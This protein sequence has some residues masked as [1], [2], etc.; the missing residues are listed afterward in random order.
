MRVLQLAWKNLWHRPLSALLSI[1][2]TALAILLVTVVLQVS[3]QTEQRFLRNVAGIDMVI[4]AKGSPLQL[5]LSS[6]YHIDN[7]TGNIN[8]ARAQRYMRNP[9]VDK[10]I[11]LSYGDSYRGY[12]IV[13][14]TTD[15]VT[16]YGVELEKGNLFQ[17]DMEVVLGAKVAERLNLTIGGHFHGT[18]GMEE[19]DDEHVH[20]GHS[21][22]VVGVLKESQTVLDQ[23]ILCNM[24]SV[25]AVHKEEAD[26][27]KPSEK[28]ITAVLLSFR[29]PMGQM[30]LPRQVNAENGMQAALPAI[31]VNRMLN[32]MGVGIQTL[33]SLAYLIML[34]AGLSVFFS[35]LN[36]LKE[37]KYELAL[38]R[39]LGARPWHLMGLL[40]V[41]GLLVVIVGFLTGL[42]MSRLT[43]WVLSL[44]FEEQFQFVLNP[45][46]VAPAEWGLL[47]GTL[48]LGLL[49]SF[50][51][52]LRAMNINI[53]KTLSGD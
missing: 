4:G 16:H 18:H 14:T 30:I 13:G 21:Y 11:P 26:S 19:K 51:P 35:M 42:V 8:Y 28:D 25:W 45:W 10:A 12:R 47:G 34:L 31:E 38:L 20:E 9:M 17:E 29:N 37:R 41:E 36:A 53:S 22:H 49:A 15:Y 52:A 6:V 24:A 46:N 2:L 1:I 44:T 39:T 7:P 32:L 50:L 48:I 23:L 40:L 27:A 3:N 33:R 5:I 43:L